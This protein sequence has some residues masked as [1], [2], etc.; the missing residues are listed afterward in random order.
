VLPVTWLYVPA[1]RPDRFAKAAAS[2]ADVVILDLEDAVVPAHKAEAR[3]NVL[4]WLDTAAPASV[5]VRVNALDTP[6]AQDDLRALTDVPAL[7]AVRLP[8]VQSPADVTGALAALGA[9]R[10]GLCC[11]IESARGVEAAYEIASAP[12]VAAIGLGEADLAA[13][14]GVTDAVGLAW[15]RSRIV[16][17]A[18]AAGLPAPAMSVYPHVAHLAGL[19]S[20][21]LAGRR[22]GFLGRAAI[23]PRQ[24]PVIAEAFRP[25]EADVADAREVIEAFGR[26]VDDGSGVIALEDG[27]MIDPAL[28][29]QAQ[30]VLDRAAP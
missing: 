14:L 1:D 5:E 4:Q 8:K 3:A 11:L 23:H 10:C 13:D 15:C 26:G 19:H 30:A 25:S 28:I 29:R 12:R 9:T 27:R 22:L 18:R 20:S 21:S 6:W 2:G 16:V 24:V 17:A 7:R